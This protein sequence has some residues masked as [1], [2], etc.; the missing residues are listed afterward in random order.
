MIRRIAHFVA[1]LYGLLFLAVL[2]FGIGALG[3]VAAKWVMHLI[4]AAH[5]VYAGALCISALLVLLFAALRVPIAQLMLL[6]YATGTQEM[7]LP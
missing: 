5:Y 6:G 4:A 3:Y 1:D 2:A 7:L